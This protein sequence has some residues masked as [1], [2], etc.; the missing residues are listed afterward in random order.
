MANNQYVN[1]VIFGN[2]TIIDI[3]DTTATA[4]DVLN[5]KYFY[6]ASGQKV[7][8]TGVAGSVTQ[9]QDGYI[10]LPSTGGGGGT[11]WQTIINSNYTIVSDSP[12]YVSIAPFDNPAL[13]ANQTWRVT[14]G[15]NTYTYTTE[16]S[17]QISGYFIGNSGV[18]GGT[19]D[20]SGCTWWAYMRTAT[21]LVFITTDSAGTKA[22]KM[23]LQQSS[24]GGESWSWMGKNP[25]KVKT[26]LDE[27]KYLKDT[28]FATWTPT[29]TQ[30][31]LAAGTTL[32]AYTADFDSYDYIVLHRF[33]THFEY[34]TSVNPHVDNYYF[35]AAYNAIGYASNY[36]NMTA[37]TIN[38]VT[39][40]ATIT[41][42][43]LDYKNSSGANS[44]ASQTYGVYVSGL[45][46]PGTSTTS[47]TPKTSAVYARCG[48]SH[49]STAAAE[50]VNQ[51]TSYYE[52][53][54]EIWRV[55][56]GTSLNGALRKDV[57]DMWLNGF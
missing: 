16:Y 10:V 36:S 15:S 38:S 9:D 7:Q 5:G 49:F 45:T 54:I 57:H 17:S 33:H 6:T 18:V 29:T 27:K 21:Q 43:G 22:I 35:E 52:Q 1:K 32:D 53:A 11:T 48:N 40:T 14:W 55:D 41:G 28:D 23:E 37:D 34:S 24:G 56:R 31:T 19:D 8:G 42:Y 44:Y 30:T 3:S 20:G 25:T 12:N 50:V 13:G 51:N 39:G 2:N 47:I 4:S 26:S 46:T